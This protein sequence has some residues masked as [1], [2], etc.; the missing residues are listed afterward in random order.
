MSAN[1]HSLKLQDGASMDVSSSS[2]ATNKLMW[3]MSWLESSSNNNICVGLYVY[4]HNIIYT[5]PGKREKRNPM[6]VPCL[7]E[8]IQI[9]TCVVARGKC[10]HELREIISSSTENSK[11]I[12]LKLNNRIQIWNLATDPK[13]RF[14]VSDKRLWTIFGHTTN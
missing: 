3:I 1:R 4:T 12:W 6:S 5:A 14:G 13:E 2:V 7:A 11:A 9:W 8:R 10:L